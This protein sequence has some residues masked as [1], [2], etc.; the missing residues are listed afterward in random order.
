MSDKAASTANTQPVQDIQS[1]QLSWPWRRHCQLSIQADG[2]RFLPHIR[3]AL[4]GARQYVDMELY[5]C[6]SGVLFDEWLRVLSA[7][8]QR[9]VRVR[10][11]LDV[12]GSRELRNA[13]RQRLQD[14]GVELCWF[15]PVQ[16]FRPVNAL[17]RDHRKLI[18]VDNLQAWIGGMGINDRYDPRIYGNDAWLDA[19]VQVSGPVVADCHE[20]FQQ[21]WQLAAQGPVKSALRWRF[22]RQPTPPISKRKGR[23]SWVRLN[24]AR[25]GSNNPLIR[26]MVR[27]ILRA[28]QDI[29]LCT[30]Y[31]LPPRSLFK[32]L[33]FAAKR[34]VR[35][36]ITVAGPAT[37]HPVVRHAG[38]HLYAPLLSAGISIFEYQPR[39][40]HLKAARVDNWST[41]GSFN[42]DRWNSNW[43]LEANLEI[44]DQGFVVAMQALQAGIEADSTSIEPAR[45]QTRS[46]AHRWRSEFAY[47]LGTHGIK[48][49]RKVG[50]RQEHTPSP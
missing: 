4:E 42:Y 40:M 25:G 32:A 26:A 23:V 35:V 3:T 33:L 37:D 47:W 46:T 34:G 5:M 11:L 27:R 2:M 21:A 41:L 19:M 22:Q 20:L 38:Q 39:F 49:L 18:I 12:I 6:V 28:Q 13:D 30:P 48:M 29:W 44:V 36:R 50:V 31:F 8:I 17:V 15:N 45:W 43:N 10:L 9:G 16:L 14:A 1:C 7:A 24:A